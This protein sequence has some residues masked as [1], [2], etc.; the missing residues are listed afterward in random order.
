[1]INSSKKRATKKKILHSVGSGDLKKLFEK[2]NGLCA[3]MGVPLN[4]TRDSNQINGT[5]PPDRISIDRINN[6]GGYTLD[7]IQLTCVFVNKWRGRARL[8]EFI[9]Y[10]KLVADK[11]K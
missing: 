9:G 11:F 2:Q 4:I 10:C 7:N 3:I 1:M 5:C 8:E 6:D